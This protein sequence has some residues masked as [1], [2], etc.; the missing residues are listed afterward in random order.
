MPLIR[1]SPV[2]LAVLFWCLSTAAVAGELAYTC[3]V[4]H[5]YQ[6]KE[7]GSLETSPDSE[8]EKQM[9]KNP[10]TISRETG[11]IVGKSSNLDTSLAKSTRVIRQGSAEN[12]FEAVADFGDLQS[13]TH[14]YRVIKVEAYRKWSEKPFV[15]M[16]D[17]EIV[18][19]I[20][21]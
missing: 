2:A 18:T 1:T 8:Q 14:P 5:V 19:G 10:F 7:N 12:S 16:A 21:K 4:H 6:L 3:T 13:G 11:A 20:C 17:M 15:A 9:R